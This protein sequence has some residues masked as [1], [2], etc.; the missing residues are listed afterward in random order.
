MWEREQLVGRKALSPAPLPSILSQKPGS[1]MSMPLSSH[2]VSFAVESNGPI[3]K[4]PPPEPCLPL[5]ILL[6]E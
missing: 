6:L 1:T 5:P 3:R 2:S 4:T